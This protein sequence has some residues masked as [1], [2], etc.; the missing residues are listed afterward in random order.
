[1][2]LK[3]DLIKLL[4]EIIDEKKY[5][6]IALNHLFET[7]SYSNLEKAFINNMLNITL[8]N[9][10]YIDYVIM[11]MAK[12]PKRY[13]KHILRLSI[14]QILY[15]DSD[16]KG[17]IYEA[18]ELAKNQNEYQAKFVNATLRNFLN[19]KEKIYE[20]AS[21]DI[22]YSYP[23]WLYYKIKKQFGEKD[24]LE[25]LKSYKEKVIFLLE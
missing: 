14:A 25:V 7:N 4:T 8:K 12:S 10:I 24:Y 18:V 23:K 3:I 6:N 15:S 11:N 19:F 17:V 16:E 20:N 9:L 13:I 1:M 2:K 5:S 21:E 22:R